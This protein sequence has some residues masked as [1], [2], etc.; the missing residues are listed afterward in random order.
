MPA[1]IAIFAFNRPESLAN[2]FASL[3]LNPLYDESEKFVFID[4]PRNDKDAILIKEVERIALAETPN[5]KSYSTNKGLGTSIITGIS[6]ILRTYNKVIVIE[7]DLRLMPG[8]LTFMNE[9]LNAYKHD[10]RILSVCGY[11]LKIKCPND[12]HSSVYLGDRASSWGWATWANRW[13]KVDWNV[14]DW[15]TFS[16]DKTRIHDFNRRGS[17]MFSMLSDYMHGHNHSWAI[18][19]CYHQYKYNLYSIHPIKSLVDN[20]GFG[21]QATNCKQKYNRF[22]IELTQYIALKSEEVNILSPNK[23]IIRQLHRYHSIP[24]RIYSKLRKIFNI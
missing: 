5:V 13:S 19:F 9:A 20:E 1:P 17:D 10:T 22:K 21:K 23:K 12:Y 3:R 24:L 6:E 4:G 8:F 2:M 14:S 15:K 11:S 7:D 18:R 16:S